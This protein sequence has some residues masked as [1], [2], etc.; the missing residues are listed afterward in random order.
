MSKRAELRARY[1]QG[2]Y[3]LNADE[4]LATTVEDFVFEDPAEPKAVTRDMLADY[5][6]RWDKW[7]RALG[8]DNSWTLKH[9]VRQDRDG[10]LTDWEWW[11]LRGTEI[12]GTAIV[13]T[14]D[15]GVLSEVI[16]YFDRNIRHPQI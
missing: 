14:S 9:E 3:E 10:I 15:Y 12:C 16:T 1:I 5:M 11:A 8:A 7:T 6:L 2:W 4:L 13:R